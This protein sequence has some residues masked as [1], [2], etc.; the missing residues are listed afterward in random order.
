MSMRALILIVVF[1]LGRLTAQDINILLAAGE[2][3]PVDRLGHHDYQGGM[4]VL[5]DCLQQTAGFY[6]RRGIELACDS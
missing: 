1:G 6:T 3:V 5:R 2:M 4:L